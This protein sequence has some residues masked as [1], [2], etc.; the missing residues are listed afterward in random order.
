MNQSR[1]E[2]IKA[3]M[4]AKLDKMDEPTRRA[5]I[6]ATQARMML[7]NAARKAGYPLETPEQIERALNEIR[8]AVKD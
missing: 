3:R 7:I 8:K 6:R 5:V 4:Q 1:R 2:A